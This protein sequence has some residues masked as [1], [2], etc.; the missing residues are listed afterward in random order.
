MEAVPRTS[1]LSLQRLDDER[2]AKLSAADAAG[3]FATLYARHHQALY[4][5]CATI[6]RDDADAQD[7]LQA[8]W[9]HA[10]LALRRGQRDAPLRPWLFRIA[11]NESISILRR[12]AR[13]RE[14]MVVPMGAPPSAEEDVLARERFTQMLEDLRTLPERARSAL[15]M[16]ELTGLSHEEIAGALRITVAAAKQSVYEAR[17]GLQEQARGRAMECGEIRVRV[18]D[19]DRRVLRGRVVRAHIRHCPD[20]AAFAAAIGERREAFHVLTPTLGLAASGVILTRVIGGGAGGAAAVGAS[21]AGGAATGGVATGGVA[22]GAGA[23]G[24]VA[25]G[26]AGAGSLATTG[27]ATKALGASLLAKSLAAASVAVTAAGITVAVATGPPHVHHARGRAPHPV[28]ASTVANATSSPPST[29]RA[30]VKRP[31]VKRRAAG[32]PAAGRPPH[33]PLAR[34]RH[35]GV[36]PHGHGRPKPAAVR[37]GRSPR[38][39]AGHG[40]RR[41]A[42]A[43]H[44]APGRSAVAHAARAQGAHRR[45]AQGPH[46]RPAQGHPAQVHQAHGR[47]AHGHPAHGRPAHAA[48]GHPAHRRRVHGH[49]AHPGHATKK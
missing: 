2:L 29:E 19:G 7:A 38:A 6:V 8:T 13:G 34:G 18:S 46:R 48:H 31:A 36:R 44:K 17:C 30:G 26:A 24:G 22:T 39:H 3:A 20:C 4:R 27:L 41:K 49:P 5:Y 23:T 45:P 32:P 1:R 35:H 40:A 14:A 15:V 11:H 25:T 16:R 12:R 43:A 9:L 47:R 21:A 37:H 28:A 33:R 42:G 10:L